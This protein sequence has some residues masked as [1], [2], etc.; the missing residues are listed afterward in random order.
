MKELHNSLDWTSIEEDLKGLANTLPM[1]KHDINR[2]IKTLR[3]EVAELGNLEVENRRN[4]T[5]I[6]A[7]RCQEKVDKINEEL[8]LIHKFHLMSLLAQ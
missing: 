5:R 4:H 3:Q 1:F 2:F 6:T 8:K 7:Q